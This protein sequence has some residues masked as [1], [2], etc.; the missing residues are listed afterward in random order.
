MAQTLR[1]FADKLKAFNV[2]KEAETVI[3][4]NGDLAVRLNQNQ[5]VDGETS[6]DKEITPS[7][8]SSSYAAFKSKLNSRAGFGTPDLRVTGAFQHG[9]R[10]I[11]KSKKYFITSSDG[12]TPELTKKYTINVFGL[13]KTNSN[14]FRNKNDKDLVEV[15]RNKVGL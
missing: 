1:E 14:T 9:M 5:M 8:F 6:L 3:L 10:M 2:E 11:K 7:Y 12:K 15:W 13:N 4:N